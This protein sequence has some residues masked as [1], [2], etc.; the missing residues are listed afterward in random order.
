MPSLRFVLDPNLKI[1]ELGNYHD[2]VVAAL[3]LF[4]SPAAPDFGARFVGCSKAEIE[5][6][7]ENRILESDNRST[8]A[9]LASLKAYFRVD[10]NLRCRE[11]LKDNLSRYF[12]SVERTRADRVRLDE[13]ILEGWKQHSNASA[14]LINQI[15][16]ALKLRHWLAHGRYWT[17][18]LGQKYDFAGVYLLANVIVSG[19]HLDHWDERFPGKQPKNPPPQLN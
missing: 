5:R 16:A 15:R 18:K 3:R 12:R 10:F 13:D 11:R 7:L 1:E 14:L 17:P 4:F 2:D 9:V 6:Q 8:F 19:F